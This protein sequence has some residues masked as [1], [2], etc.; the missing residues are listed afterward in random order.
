[1]NGMLKSLDKYRDTNRFLEDTS[2]SACVALLFGAYT[3]V[4]LLVTTPTE[5]NWLHADP[6]MKIFPRALTL[7]GIPVL[8][9]LL[10]FF[11]NALKPLQPKAALSLVKFALSGSAVSII[12]L[13]TLRLM[14]GEQLPAFVPPEESLKPGYLLGM[15]AGLVEELVMRLVLTPLLFVAFR[16]RMGFHGAVIAAIVVAALCFVL[17]HEAGSGGQALVFQHAVTRFIVPGVIM[18][19]AVFYVSPVFLVALHCTTHV[20]I[21]L[22]FV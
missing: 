17:W 13:V 16:K 6:V 15:S 14:A 12:A 19:L 4:L 8:S 22:L 20:M 2:A 3:L 5:T 10:F 21:P 11:W 18:G 1:M 7:W 9:V